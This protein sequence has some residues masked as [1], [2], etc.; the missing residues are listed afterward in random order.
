MQTEVRG[1]ISGLLEW[2]SKAKEISESLD[3][4]AGAGWLWE[5]H[6]LKGLTADYTE[7]TQEW[8]LYVTTTPRN[9][10]GKGFTER[11]RTCGFH[12]AVERDSDL[13]IRYDTHQ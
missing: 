8:F 4:R 7:D 6:V 9:I 2:S 12:A 1:R 11:S 5:H 13:Y 3:S 10:R